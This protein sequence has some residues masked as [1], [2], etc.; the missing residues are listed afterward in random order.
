MCMTTQNWTVRGG[1]YVDDVGN[2]IV[3]GHDSNNIHIITAGGKRHRI[4]LTSSD[5]LGFPLYVAYR[6]SDATL[7]IG[8]INNF[9]AFNL[10]N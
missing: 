9:L 5:G 4:L 2:T 10:E 1:I 7:V 8:R 3:C 6:H